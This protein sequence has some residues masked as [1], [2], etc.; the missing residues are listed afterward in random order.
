MLYLTSIDAGGLEVGMLVPNGSVPETGERGYM[1][2]RVPRL[3]M[4]YDR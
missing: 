1:M 3:M 4:V 2:S